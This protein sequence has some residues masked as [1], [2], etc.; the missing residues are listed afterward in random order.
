MAHLIPLFRITLLKMQNVWVCPPP[1]NNKKKE[2]RK[3][4]EMG[5]LLGL[6]LLKEFISGSDF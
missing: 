5:L 2:L 6:A 1:R 4:V 3:Q